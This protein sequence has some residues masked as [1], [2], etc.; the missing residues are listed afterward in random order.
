[1]SFPPNCPAT[2]RPV[3]LALGGSAM[4]LFFLSILLHELGHSLVSQ[5][6]GIPVPR[7]TLLFIGGLAEIAREPDDARSELKIA[8][9][10][11]AVSVLLSMGFALLRLAPRPASRWESVAHVFGWLAVTN[12]A[13]VIFNMFPGYPLDGGRVLRALIWAKTGTAAARDLYLLPHR[14]RLQ[15]AADRSRRVD[16]L[17]RAQPRRL[18][19]SPHRLL[20]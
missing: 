15:L 18:E 10:G 9:G 8:L 2:R 14:H 12:L 3:Y 7:I 17:D 16:A 20:P 19:L 5:R 13:L 1:M 11:P 6:C 4:L